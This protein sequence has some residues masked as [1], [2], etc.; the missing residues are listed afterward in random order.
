MQREDIESIK[1]KHR[2][3]WVLLSDC[4][5][6]EFNEPLSGV[7]VAHSKDRQEIYNKQME[8]KKDLCIYYTGKIPE[9][10]GVMF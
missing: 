9:D 5:L 10:L 4:E 2:D 8:I 7:V 3:E 6:D 1:E